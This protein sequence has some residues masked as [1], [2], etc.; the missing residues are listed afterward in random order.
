M[1][2]STRFL[3]R[4]VRGLALAAAAAAL[5]ACGG[6]DDTTLGGVAAV[7]D[8][9]AGGT[10][11]VACAGGSP[12]STTTSATGQWQVAI[13]GQTLPCAVQVQGGTVGGAPYTATLHSI[14]TA[15][16]NL[17]ITPLTDLVVARSVGGNPQAWFQ[18]PAFAGIDQAALQAA[19][20]QVVAALGLGTALGD[21]DPLTASF[22]AASGDPIDDLL[23]AL[24]AALQTL[25]AEYAALLTAAGQGNFAAFS[26]LP[27]AVTQA[28]G[29]ATGGGN[30]GGS[31]SCTSGV[32]MVF[33]RGQA[34]GPY[35]DGQKVC[36]EATTTSLKI[37]DK[38]FSNPTTN[39]VVVAPFAA[40]AFVDAGLS[41]EVVLNNGALYEINIAK[42]NAV[43]AADFHGQ[44]MPTASGGQTLTVEVS[45]SGTLATSFTVPNQ[46]PPASEAEFCADPSS[47]PNLTG[48]Q[49][50]NGVTLTITGCSFANNIGTIAAS[51]QT[52]GLSVPYVVRFVYGS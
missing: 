22:T 17:N 46:T 52:G 39:P 1:R 9:I 23:Q 33:A 16:G 38:T 32:E 2:A 13:S 44:F 47:D 12:L 35:T 18:A 42:T 11:Q 30:T 41:Y 51:A 15:F 6:D 40:Y 36:A 5:V 26:A 19:V 48:L 37:G 14:A 10:V 4:P 8:P 28:L 49:L 7:G 34:D 25:G 29:S 50:Q 45:I 24:A 21:R 3:A 43:S 27:A 20:D 31:T